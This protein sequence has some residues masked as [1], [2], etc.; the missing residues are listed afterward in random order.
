MAAATSP[1]SG[2]Q[3]GVA[4]VCK[5]WDVPRSSFYAARQQP[6][7]TTPPTPA[8]RRG[9]RPAVSDEDLLAAIRADLVRSPW[10]GEGHRKVWARL[11]VMEGIRASRKRVLRLMRQQALL[12]PHRTRPRP[13]AA[14]DRHIITDAPNVMWAVDATEIT[15]VH[16]GKV[17]LFGVAE[18]WNAE[19]LGWHVS[20]RATRFEATQAV[21]MAVRQIF[22]HL[23]AGAARGVALR[24]DHGSN[25][26]AEHFQKQIR[27]WGIAPSY[28]FVGQPETNGVIERLF[29]TL[30]EQLVHGRIFHTIDE[31]RDAVRSFVARYNAA[32]LIEKNGHRSPLEIRAAWNKLTA[33]R[34]A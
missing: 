18:H 2:R 26:M 14:H 34:A 19:L 16:D 3:Y 20:K 27:F 4:R 32:W 15:T 11:R 13:E 1:A 6:T 17:W 31:I 30:K 33:R 8:R 10:H 25:F 29:R 5:V 24:H 23:S 28:A 9:P 12:S 21:G 7:A 22:G